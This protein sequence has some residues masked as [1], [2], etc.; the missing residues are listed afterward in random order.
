M[1]GSGSASSIV[2]G[3]ALNWDVGIAVDYTPG[4]VGAAAGVLKIGQ[5]Q[6]NNANYTHG[7]T[8]LYTNGFERM[9]II[10]DGSVGI[11]TTAPSKLLDVNGTSIFRGVITSRTQI[12]VNTANTDTQSSVIVGVPGASNYFTG[13]AVGDLVL[14]NEANTNILLGFSGPSGSENPALKLGY[15]GGAAKATVSTQRNTL[16]DGAGN[17]TVNGTVS[18]KGLTMTAGT[19]IDQIYTVTD[20]LTLTTTWQDTSVNA[21]ELATGTYIVQVYANDYAV[22]GGQYDQYY[23]GVMSWF[24]SNTN[25]G[26]SD[27]IALH[28]AGHAPNTGTIYLR[29]LRT[30]SAD[31]ADLKLQI[32]GDTANTGASN[33]IY[34]FRRMI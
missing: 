3:T 17:M 22:G 1:N 27:E 30:V 21:A 7:V 10:N 20:S 6:K 12:S 33:Y 26:T 31:V 5:I 11:G 23:S 9:R 24:A 19:N 34:K 14:R 2:V 8:A 32:A 29:I 28:R 18:H 25:D 13:S 15:N 16:D 4:T